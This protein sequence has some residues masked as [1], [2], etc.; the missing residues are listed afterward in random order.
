MPATMLVQRSARGP[1]GL[2][3]M[4]DWRS[5]DEVAET[6]ERVHA[7]RLLEIA[8]ELVAL[9]EVSEGQ[10]VLDVG[11][12]TGVAAQAASESGASVVGIDPSTGMLTVGHRERPSLKL[13][14]ANAIDLPFRDG[15]F[16]TVTGNFVL[17]HFRRYDTALFDMLRVTKLGGRIA[18]TSWSD[19]KDELQETWAELIASVVPREMLE[20]VWAAAAPWQA[21]FADRQVFEDVLIGARLRHVR[22]EKRQ[23]R[24]QYSQADYLD[25]LGIWATGRFVHEMLGDEGWPAFQER[26]RV[27]FSERFSDPLNDFRDVILAVGTKQ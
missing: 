24:F 16:D 21:K 2:P 7:L 18:L 10:R 6:Y 5:Y 23:F 9:A 22:T 27:T 15:T 11:T 25:G 26:A 14:A 17:S 8:R 13:A 19:T 1:V 12:G 3:P 20:P 4:N